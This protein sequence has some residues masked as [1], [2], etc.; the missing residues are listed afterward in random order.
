M[1]G[2]AGVGNVQHAMVRGGLIE[3]YVNLTAAR[4]PGMGVVA[5]LD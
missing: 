5:V 3:Q 2:P 1:E 4:P